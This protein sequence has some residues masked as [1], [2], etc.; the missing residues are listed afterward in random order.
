MVAMGHLASCT[1]R[2][3]WPDRSRIGA[4]T[5]RHPLGQPMP[6]RDLPCASWLSG[7]FLVKPQ[8]ACPGGAVPLLLPQPSA[9]LERLRD[10]LT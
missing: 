10:Y 2:G 5:P 7:R 4:H 8:T 9:A 1:S 3:P 6:H